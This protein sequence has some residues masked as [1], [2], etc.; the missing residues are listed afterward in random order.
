MIGDAPGDLKAARANDALFFPINPGH[1]DESWERFYEEAVHKFLAGDVCRRLR[2]SA[3]RRVREPA[4]G[5]A[6][7]EEVRSADSTWLMAMR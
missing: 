5:S 1:E 3:D 2:G 7:V 6:A 4:A